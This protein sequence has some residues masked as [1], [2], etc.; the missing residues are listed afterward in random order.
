MKHL[1]GSSMLGL[2]IIL[3]MSATQ[4]SVLRPT[5][6]EMQTGN[7]IASAVVIPEQV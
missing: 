5:S 4:V 3:G 7:V 2:V 6:M 1:Y